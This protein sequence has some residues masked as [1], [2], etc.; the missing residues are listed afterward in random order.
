M[1]GPNNSHARTIQTI[2]R[3][4]G[5]NVFSDM[6]IYDYEVCFLISYNFL[7]ILAAIWFAAGEQYA[8][9]ALIFGF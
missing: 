7:K 3:S 6:T 5:I 4:I 8:G 2:Q 1:G 9:Y